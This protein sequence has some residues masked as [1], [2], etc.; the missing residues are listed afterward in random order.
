[1]RTIGQL[2]A[3]IMMIVIVMIAA[4]GCGDDDKTVNPDNNAPM[5]VSVTADPDTFF[6]NQ[7]TTVTVVD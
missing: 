6:A 3:L 1:M 4:A 2:L 7:S 5:I